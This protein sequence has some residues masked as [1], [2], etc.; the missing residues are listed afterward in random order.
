M[1]LA[2]VERSA[3]LVPILGAPRR[4]WMIAPQQDSLSCAFLWRGMPTAKVVATGN[5]EIPPMKQAGTWNAW[6]LL[7][8]LS[9]A[10]TT[11]AADTLYDDFN[12]KWRPIQIGSGATSTFVRN[13]VEVSL[14]NDAQGDGQDIFGSGLSSSCAVAWDFDL[15]ASFRLLDWPEHNGTRVALFLGSMTDIENDSGVF[16][17]RDSYSEAD[18]DIPLELYVFYADQGQIFVEHE[19][20][21]TTGH[22]RFQRV[23]SIVTGYY[24]SAGNWV[25]IGSSDAG[26]HELRFAVLAYSHDSVFAD[27]DVRAA[28]DAVRVATGSLTGPTC[29][30]PTS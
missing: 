17:E 22:L 16:L 27:S 4:S 30:F 20:A 7:T 24:R 23:G 8:A 21:D 3:L 25:E 1:N 2:V 15:R 6:L 13:R 9:L 5:Q 11:A 26:T 12:T 18:A 10:V 29:P 28:F 14:P 19:T